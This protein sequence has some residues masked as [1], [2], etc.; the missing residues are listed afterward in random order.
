MSS[1]SSSPPVVLYNREEDLSKLIDTYNKLVQR[2]NEA[3]TASAVAGGAGAPNTAG[4]GGAREL[5][6]LVGQPGNGKTTLGYALQSHIIQSRRDNAGGSG[7]AGDTFFISGKFDPFDHPEPFSPLLQAF[8][9]YLDQIIL[10]RRKEQQLDGTNTTSSPKG[11]PVDSV[12]ASSSTVSA[13]NHVERVQRALLRIMDTTELQSLYSII[14]K[15]QE[16]MEISGAAVVSNNGVVKQ[17]QQNNGKSS[18]SSAYISKS[19]T[20][21]SNF[22]VTFCNMIRAISHPQYPIVLFIDNGQHS[23]NDTMCLDII[24]VL[25]T[26]TKIT[27][28]LCMIAFRPVGVKHPFSLCLRALESSGI[29][30][31]PILP[32]PL[33]SDNI[34]TILTTQ[35][36][37]V[38][39]SNALNNTTTVGDEDDNDGAAS[40]CS[41]RKWFCD[42]MATITKGNPLSI[43]L[44][45]QL[46]LGNDKAY[47][48]ELLQYRSRSGGQDGNVPTP[49]MLQIINGDVKTLFTMLYRIMPTSTSP[50]SSSSICQK[51]CNVA[52]CM[53]SKDSFFYRINSRKGGSIS[54]GGGGG[55]EP[56]CVLDIDRIVSIIGYPGIRNDINDALE[57]GVEAGIL[58]KTSAAP[59][60]ASSSSSN[61]Y[62]YA[63]ANWTYK[64]CIYNLLPQDD[65][66][67]HH[68][69]IGNLYRQEYNSSNN[70]S[71]S[72]NSSSNNNNNAA[73]RKLLLYNVVTHMK[74]G[75]GLLSPKG[76]EALAT[77]CLECGL[78]TSSW[79]EYTAATRYLDMG[80][81]LLQAINDDDDDEA[82]KKKKKKLK[83]KHL[84]QLYW[85]THHDL[86]L[87]LY[88]ASADVYKS[89]GKYSEMDSRLMEILQ[90][91]K[92]DSIDHFNAYMIQMQSLIARMMHTDAISLALKV[93]PKL[94]GESMPYKSKYVESELKSVKKLLFSSSSSKDGGSKE[95]K[96]EQALQQQQSVDYDDSIIL[97]RKPMVDEKKLGAMTI[98]N[99]LLS[100][101]FLGQQGI[102]G[103]SS[104]SSTA[105]SDDGKGGSGSCLI[106][107]IACRMV[108]TTLQY[109]VTGISAIGL[110]VLGAVLCTGGTGL[111]GDVTTTV[112]IPK[113]LWCSEMAVQLV[114]SHDLPDAK[115][116]K[117]R[118]MAI[119]W[120]IVSRYNKSWKQCQEPLKIAYRLCMEGGDN[121]V[122]QKISFI[123]FRC[124]H[125]N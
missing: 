91:T 55:G 60:E 24:K 102:G 2:S 97:Q 22:L 58:T 78:D 109:G 82:I 23:T 95:F 74:L 99:Y 14:P 84:D 75:M 44:C 68:T 25:M 98:L 16:L 120:G 30:F 54:V 57:V 117:G 61:E 17:Q 100:A 81:K 110:S 92:K 105:G 90:N 51:L 76:K 50:S 67:L 26:D 66:K 49:T 29:T 121:E 28:L 83:P 31:V 48:L 107:I 45:F 71:A 89:T 38:E 96:K 122:R 53:G 52:S 6:L 103:S 40:S 42:W 64:D 46:L 20:N 4:G 12:H 11:M 70:N 125:S 27:G 88:L 77:L 72:N 56:N 7:A 112:D 15:L 115:P 85:K 19:T 8:T 87:S 21:K 113:G 33:N 63:F 65:K 93:Y 34:D 111:G 73:S 9:S 79:T 101:S 86:A 69:A 39:L 43:Q 36:Q 80:I 116:C 41:D 62:Y 3:A 59:A 35:V 106:P 104:S 5:V 108:K 123:Y 118:V 124:L 32:T 13:V 119:H 1:S 10:S 94:A 37:Y 114:G 47:F 18:S